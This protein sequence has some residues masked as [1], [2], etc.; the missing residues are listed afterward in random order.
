[1]RNMDGRTISMTIGVISTYHPWYSYKVSFFKTLEYLMEA[2]T[3]TFAQRENI[4]KLF[5]KQLL[6]KLGMAQSMPRAL[7][8]SDTMYARMW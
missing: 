4:L 1:M 8:F 2:I 6:N 3:F 7:A 5:M